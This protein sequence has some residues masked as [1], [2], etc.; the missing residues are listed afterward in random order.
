MGIPHLYREIVK[1]DPSIIVNK[2]PACTRLFLDFNGIIHNSANRIKSKY[3][4]NP[5]KY[6]GIDIEDILFKEIIKKIKP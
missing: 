3:I 5:N 4:E 2:I 1:K 6:Q